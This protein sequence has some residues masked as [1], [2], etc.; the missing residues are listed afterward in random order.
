MKTRKNRIL[1]LFLAVCMLAMLFP[2]TAFASSDNFKIPTATS[3]DDR[4]YPAYDYSRANK[5]PRE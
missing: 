5:L 1:A 2:V 3:L 4:P